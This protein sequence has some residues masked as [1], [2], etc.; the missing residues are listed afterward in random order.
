MRVKLWVMTGG[1]A[2]VSAAAAGV[3][4]IGQ[5]PSTAGTALKGV[6][7]ASVSLAVWG[8]L[9][10]LLLLV[11]TP[12]SQAISVGTTL[13]AGV[14][15]ALLLRRFG[16]HDARLLAAVLFATLVVSAVFF[17]RLRAPHAHG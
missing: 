8:I 17:W 11:R 4:V 14:F 9:T 7:W 12:R 16:Y 3:V 1:V 15:A 13:T 5:S 10:T 2:A 6:L